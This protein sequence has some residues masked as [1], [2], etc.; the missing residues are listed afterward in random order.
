[1]NGPKSFFYSSAGLY[2]REQNI[3]CEM[4]KAISAETL[5]QLAASHPS[6]S[7]GHSRSIS[8]KEVLWR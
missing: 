2:G 6:S 1:M 3:R 7:A 5:W 4:E 8:N